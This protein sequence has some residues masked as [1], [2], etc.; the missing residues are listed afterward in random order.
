[1]STTSQQTVQPT[2]SPIW[3]LVGVSEALAELDV[4]LTAQMSIGRDAT[5]DLVLGSS[6]ISRHHAKIYVTDAGVVVEDLNSSNGTFIND[7]PLQGQSAPLTEVT[8][9]RFASL[10][11]QL[12]SNS[13]VNS[14]A[15]DA[16]NIADVHDVANTQT[17]QPAN[18]E[19]EQAAKVKTPAVSTAATNPIQQS[20]SQRLVMFMVI[21]LIVLI[22]LGVLFFFYGNM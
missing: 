18:S 9:I 15:T 10:A 5:N 6:Q 8:A 1:M 12:K 4:A 7:T 17:L 22:A 21:A 11:F 20:D 13:Q 19:V 14:T 2:N 3:Q 16:G